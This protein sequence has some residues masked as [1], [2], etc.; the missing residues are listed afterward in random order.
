M[1][2][3]KREE[4]S[5]EKEVSKITQKHY[6]V[7]P[8]VN[9][10]PDLGGAITGL[11][12]FCVRMLKEKGIIKVYVRAPHSEKLV[13]DFDIDEVPEK[14]FPHFYEYK[15]KAVVTMKT[16][17]RSY[18]LSVYKIEDVYGNLS[19]GI[20]VNIVGEINHSLRGEIQTVVDKL[21]G[22]RTFL[23]EVA[24]L[25]VGVGS[26]VAEIFLDT[27]KHSS[28]KEQQKKADNYEEIRI[29]EQRKM[30]MLYRVTMEFY[31]NDKDLLKNFVELVVQ[32]FNPKAEY[33]ILDN[34]LDTGA[35]DRPSKNYYII[36]ADDELSNIL[37]LPMLATAIGRG[38]HIPAFVE[39]VDP[40]R[41]VVLG[42]KRNGQPYT[43]RLEDFY[44][45]IYIVGM[46]GSGKSNTLEVI[47]NELREKYGDKCSIWV[48]DP[49]GTLAIDIL[50]QAGDEE[51]TYYFDPLRVGF[52]INPLELKDYDDRD[53]AVSHMISELMGIFSKVMGLNLMQAPNVRML[54][55]L[56]TLYMYKAER[57]NP[58]LP[59]LLKF[60]LKLFK[61]EVDLERIKEVLGEEDGQLLADALSLAEQMPEQSF[62]STVSRLLPFAGVPKIRKMFEGNT[63]D[64][65][66][67]MK[68]GK[69]VV[70]NISRAELPED[71]QALMMNV[72][73]M[74]LW[75]EIRARYRKAVENTLKP[76]ASSEELGLTPVILV[77]DEFQTL[78]ELKLLDII[79]S[80]ARKFGLHM[81][82]AHQNLDQL[83]QNLLKA[84]LNNT[85]VQIIMRVS[86]E[87]AERLVKNL[88][89][90]NKEVLLSLLPNLKIGEAVVKKN[91]R[92]DDSSYPQ[93][94]KIQLAPPER[95]T[96]EYLEYIVSKMKK[97]YA[98]DFF[99]KSEKLKELGKLNVEIPSDWNPKDLA[100]LY[101]IAKINGSAFHE[102][103]D[104]NKKVSPDV[105]N[106]Y[107][108]AKKIAELIGVHKEKVSKLLTK[109]AAK[110]LVKEIKIQTGN[111]EKKV[112]ALTDRGRGVLIGDLRKIIQNEEGL[113]VAKAAVDY[114]I[115]N[116]RTPIF[117]RQVLSGTIRP[118]LVVI[119]IK[120]VHEEDIYNAIDTKDV[121]LVEIES[122]VEV[123]ANPE[124]IKNNMT[125]G[126]TKI[127]KE[128]H[129]WTSDEVVDIVIKIRESLPEGLSNTIK[130]FAVNREG[131]IKEF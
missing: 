113:E 68:P 28:S 94:V 21:K 120:D 20:A 40:E 79:L 85:G 76:T 88:D 108:S 41:E 64:F 103:P 77:V 104:K 1:P 25:I 47:V 69:L 131:K 130:I 60:Y 101:A 61:K 18:P 93:I 127:S 23:E 53:M 116:S 122:P 50:L 117:F 63:I 13:L 4:K 7:R 72:I 24:E 86:G 119:P 15:Y 73:V 44:R 82:M 9:A 106:N 10:T 38:A 89:W 5:A 43:L 32:R 39:D 105:L 90:Q 22:K 19:E 6:L 118:D 34:D 45:H 65:Q 56:G 128:V 62:I 100:I 83:D 54:L 17:D 66:E 51:N 46:T 91:T 58:T 30:K 59:D 129:F 78:Q 95:N 48:L 74:R 27:G 14:N 112:Y 75:F 114:Y 11:E 8:R 67:L 31:G 97:K 36:V 107:A 3:V 110:K 37:T 125:K 2:L 29:L 126:L 111:L 52:Q 84:I 102:T 26:T 42:Y 123:K 121:I 81:V 92:S 33:V 55:Q 80:E 115:M 70:W 71:I 98:S 124:S 35:L 87:D 96:E 12:Y 109:L 57:D 49:H 99:I 16:K